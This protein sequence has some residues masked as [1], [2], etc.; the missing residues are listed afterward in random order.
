MDLSVSHLLKMSHHD[1]QRKNI[2]NANSQYQSYDSSRAPV[3]GVQ[4][5]KETTVS[6]NQMRK[7][8]DM[9]FSDSNNTPRI[10]LF[11]EVL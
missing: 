6:A 11:N 10:Q 9:A 7:I 1:L 4:R 3:R 5:L 2:D 8:T